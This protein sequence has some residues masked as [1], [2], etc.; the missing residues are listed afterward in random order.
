MTLPAIP[1]K[2][3]YADLADRHGHYCPMSTLGLR[4]GWAARRRLQGSAHQAIYLA[5]T[6]AVDGIRLALKDS[7][8]QVEERGNHQLRVADREARW[9]IGLR[10]ET[11]QRAAS[12]RNLENAAAQ[13]RLLEELR[14]AAEEDLLLIEREP[15]V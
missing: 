1:H 8:L 6:C 13:L 9:L 11:L 14:D 5:R 10:P 2:Q 15:C 4:I 3:F 7:E 12:Y